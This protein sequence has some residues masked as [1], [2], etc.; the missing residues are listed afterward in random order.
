[1]DLE[2]EPTIVDMLEKADNPQNLFIS[3]FSQDNVHPDLEPIFN[4]YNIKFS[5]RKT[6]TQSARGAGFARYMT[7]EA[8]DL[9]S[10]KYYLQIDSH[11]RFDQSWDSHLINSYERL[12]PVWGEYLFSTYPPSY[13]YDENG[14]VLLMNGPIPPCVELLRNKEFY[15]FEPKYTEYTGGDIGQETAYFCAGFVFGYREIFDRAK[16]DPLIYFNGEEQLMSI[17]YHQR[18]IK[19]VCPPY[20][21]IYHDYDGVHRKRIWEVNPEI[22]KLKKLSKFRVLEFFADMLDDQFG[23]TDRI[24]Y[25]NFFYNHVRR[26]PSEYAQ[27]GKDDPMYEEWTQKYPHRV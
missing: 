26:F 9:N 23:I 13:E 8:L 27:L 2:L 18:D 25:T 12:K 16:H 15:R 5:Y 14:K 7:R 1:M 24:R 4:K 21:P 22:D 19:I 17:R 20:V 3:V 11:M 6:T 10:Y